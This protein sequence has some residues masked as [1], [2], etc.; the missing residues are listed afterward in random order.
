[1]KYL[2]PHLQKQ[3]PKT[4]MICISKYQR[5]ILQMFAQLLLKD[6]EMLLNQLVHSVITHLLLI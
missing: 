5:L 2:N 4:E 1:M 6:D 3:I